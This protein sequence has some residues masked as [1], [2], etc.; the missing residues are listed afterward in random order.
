MTNFHISGV[1]SSDAAATQFC[2]I[3]PFV[4]RKCLLYYY[5]PKNMQTHNF[6]DKSNLKKMPN[7]SVINALFSTTISLFCHSFAKFHFCRALCSQWR[8]QTISLSMAYPF[9][10]TSTADWQLSTFH[11]AVHFRPHT[12]ETSNAVLELPIDFKLCIE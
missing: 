4:I 1:K 2:G 11:N 7:H 5:E 6:M 12:I 3:P 8:S 9:H 10:T